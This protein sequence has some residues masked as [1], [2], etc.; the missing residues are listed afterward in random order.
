MQV[1]KNVKSA[2]VVKLS[3][4]KSK[5]KKDEFDQG[6]SYEKVKS[7]LEQVN[8]DVARELEKLDELGPST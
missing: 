1:A 6:S 5:R 4:T 3:V 2:I 8:A 7:R